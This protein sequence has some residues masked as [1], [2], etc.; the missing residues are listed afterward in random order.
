MIIRRIAILWVIIVVFC[1]TLFSQKNVI[2]TAEQPFPSPLKRTLMPRRVADSVAL[3]SKLSLLVEHYHQRGYLAF[4]ID[5]FHVSGDTVYVDCFIGPCYGSKIIRIADS[6]LSALPPGV[7]SRSVR[8]GTAIYSDYAQFAEKVVQ[9]Y[10]NNGHPFCQV[11]IEPVDFECDTIGTLSVV[12]GPSIVFDSIIVKGDA[13][14]RPSFLQPYLGWRRKRRYS[15]AVV[16]Q[17]PA[18]LE[19]LPYVAISREPGVEFVGDRAYLYLFLERQRVNQFDGYI[20]LVPVSSSTG[21]VMLN[22]EVTL[23]LQNLFTIG[24]KLS[25]Q[26]RAPE[27]YSQYLDIQAEFPYLFRTPIGVA[28]SFILD[29]KDTTYLNMSYLAALQYSFAGSSSLQVNYRYTS[30][31][32]LSVSPDYVAGSDTLAADFRKSL[33]GVQLSVSHVDN[34]IQPWAGVQARAMVS[35]GTRRQLPPV[36]AVGEGSAESVKSTHYLMEAEVNGYVPIGKRWGWTAGL[37][38]AT[39]FGGTALYNDLF[40]IGGTHTLQGFDEQ[41]LFASTYLIARTEFRFRVARLSYLCAFFN[42][43][44]YERNLKGAMYNDWPFGF[45]VGATIHTKAGNLYLSYALGQQKES[46][47][48]FKTGKIHF[49]IDV[50]F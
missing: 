17:I 15:E 18:L 42:A 1:G 23:K 22:G 26:W 41:S 8:N 49:G 21:K 6:T 31:A 50:S 24:E 10:E 47:V 43:A 20:G 19:R 11:S 25:L 14:V 45:G 30:S 35:A 33:W 29:K 5:T 36:Q 37:H 9:Q 3:Q 28:G 34:V 32:L 44:W 27:R 46:P 13:K 48:S 38:G 12:A 16:H 39:Q 4:S 2:F 40:R 7:P